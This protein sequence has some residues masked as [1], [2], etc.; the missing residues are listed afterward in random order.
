MDNCCPQGSGQ[1]VQ[2]K[3]SDHRLKVISHQESQGVGGAAMSGYQTAV[4][5]GMETIVKIDD[6]GRMNPALLPQFVTPLA[7]DDADHL[8]PL[9]FIF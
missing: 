4:I 8:C 7:S 9:R 6:E 5:D 3:N 1:F 2:S